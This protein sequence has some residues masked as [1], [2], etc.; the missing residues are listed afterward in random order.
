M[1]ANDLWVSRTASP[2]KARKAVNVP[3][4]TPLFII[5]NDYILTVIGPGP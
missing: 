1:H 4:E 3:I 2:V 5:E